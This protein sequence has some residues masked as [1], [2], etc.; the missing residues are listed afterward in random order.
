MM[1]QLHGCVSLDS[2]AWCWLGQGGSLGRPKQ[3]GGLLTGE[4]AR[5]AGWAAQQSHHVHLQ[6]ALQPGL[7]WIIAIAL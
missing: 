4:R 3:P 5:R 6:E 1:Q 7:A 2:H